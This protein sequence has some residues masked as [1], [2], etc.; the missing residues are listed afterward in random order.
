MRIATSDGTLL[1]TTGTVPDVAYAP[2]MQQLMGGG[3][4]F[5][6][7]TGKRQWKNL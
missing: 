3:E 2:Q 6:R 7:G 5:A 1:A 4:W